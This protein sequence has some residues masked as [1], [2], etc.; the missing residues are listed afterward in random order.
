MISNDATLRAELIVSRWV[1]AHRSGLKWPAR[2]APMGEI[3]EGFDGLLH[4][5]A[6]HRPATTLSLRSMK[7][8]ANELSALGASAI[9]WRLK[10]M[11]AFTAVCV[12]TCRRGM[13]V[14]CFPRI[15]ARLMIGGVQ[16]VCR[17][18]SEAFRARRSPALIGARNGFLRCRRAPAFS[19]SLTAQAK[20]S[21]IHPTTALSPQ[22]GCRGSKAGGPPA[23]LSCRSSRGRPRGWSGRRLLIRGQMKFVDP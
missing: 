14:E 22:S 16:R 18:S 5:I 1:A 15:V 17:R 2:R 20:I 13:S 10:Q 8:R 7:D 3:A 21:P 9:F 6:E 23:P 19:H 4:E 12:K 11:T